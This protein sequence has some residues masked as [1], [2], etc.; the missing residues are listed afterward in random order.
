MLPLPCGPPWAQGSWTPKWSL[1]SLLEKDLVTGTWDPP[2][3][4]PGPT[5]SLGPT[6]TVSGFQ[7]GINTMYFWVQ[8][9][10]VTDGMML[11]NAQL[12]NK[13]PEPA[14]LALVGLALLGAGLARR[15][16]AARC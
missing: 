6:V 4:W 7:A 8:G 16:S 11:M 12:S 14:S 10:G 13:V 3:S 1:N 2:T 9:N 15:H 5:Y